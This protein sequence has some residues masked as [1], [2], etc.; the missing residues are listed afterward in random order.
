MDTQ[1]LTQTEILPDPRGIDW[2]DGTD[3]DSILIVN[4]TLPYLLNFVNIMKL[5]MK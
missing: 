2:F 1:R 3:Q 4:M 5:C